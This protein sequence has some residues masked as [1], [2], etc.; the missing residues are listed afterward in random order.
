MLSTIARQRGI[1]VRPTYNPAPANSSDS[2]DDE[3]GE[4]GIDWPTTTTGESTQNLTELEME[5]GRQSTTRERLFGQFNRYAGSFRVKL[6]NRDKKT[7]EELE[8]EERYIIAI[9]GILLALSNSE[10][11]IFL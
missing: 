9:L 2:D 8:S 7:L 11:I 1:D 5:D 10:V 4:E 6:S 3:E